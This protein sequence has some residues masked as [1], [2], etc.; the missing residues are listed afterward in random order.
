MPVTFPGAKKQ[1]YTVQE[2][3]DE[4]GYTTRYLYWLNQE[5]RL[6]MVKVARRTFID[7][8]ELKRLKKSLRGGRR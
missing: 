1:Y 6:E 8:A 5:S 2:A 4:L 7:E 3:A